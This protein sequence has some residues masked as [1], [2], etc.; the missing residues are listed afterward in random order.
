MEIISYDRAMERNFRSMFEM[1][2]IRNTKQQ[3]WSG[4]ETRNTLFAIQIMIQPCRNINGNVYFCFMRYGKITDIF[5]KK[6]H[7]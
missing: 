6:T 4:F 3:F 7:A 1:E 5:E 2:K